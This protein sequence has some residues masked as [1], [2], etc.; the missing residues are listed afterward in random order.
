MKKADSTELTLKK[1][2]LTAWANILYKKGLIDAAR[3]GRMT[4][5]IERI[6]KG[7]KHYTINNDH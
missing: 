7:R 2:T 5:M 4:S 1:Q 3:L 6:D